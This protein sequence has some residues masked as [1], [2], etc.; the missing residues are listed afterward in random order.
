MSSEEFRSSYR[1]R[2]VS[3][4][5]KVIIQMPQIHLLYLL[6]QP[7]PF[8]QPAYNYSNDERYY[9]IGYISRD[10]DTHGLGPRSMRHI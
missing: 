1:T 4:D 7:F 3:V 2:E 10:I 5:A 6:M 9:F 8:L